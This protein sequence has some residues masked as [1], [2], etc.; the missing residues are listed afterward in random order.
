MSLSVRCSILVVTNF[1]HNLRDLKKNSNPFTLN[2]TATWI[3][4][5]IRNFFTSCHP[6][7]F[8]IHRSIHCV[9]ITR[10]TISWTYLNPIGAWISWWRHNWSPHIDVGLLSAD[11]RLVWSSL[12][13]NCWLIKTSFI[14]LEEANEITLEFLGAINLCLVYFIHD[15]LFFNPFSEFFWGS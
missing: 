6:S 13:N 15:S 2:A 14:I 12:N 11:W 10:P 1:I 7:S 3:N 4:V 5:F 9:L 8:S